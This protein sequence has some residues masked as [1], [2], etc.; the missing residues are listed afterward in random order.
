MSKP[1]DGGKKG[2]KVRV[3][4]RKNRG[5]PSRDNDWTRQFKS[6]TDQVHE[7]EQSENVR[8][9]GDSSR[10]RTII[11]GDESADLALQRGIVVAMR[12]LVAEVDDGSRLWACSVRRKLRTFLITQ[13]VPIAVGDQVMFSPVAA[14]DEESRFVSGDRNLPEGVVERVL[15][16]Q[17]LL[18]RQ[19]ERK[20]Q[21]VAANVDT[22]F[23]TLAADQPK[24]RPHLI[25]RYL[26]AVHAGKMRPIICINKSDL[27]ADEFAAEVAERYLQLGYRSLYIS[28]E[29]GIGLDE[30]RELLKD[31]TSVFV[32]PSGVGKSSIINALEPGF[33]L[34]IGTLSDLE[35]GRHT[36][37]TARLLR[38]SFG[39][40]VV[41]TPGMRQFELADVGS[42]ELEAY[43][44]EFVDLIPN[45]KFQNC[46]HRHEK[47]C[48]VIAAVENEQIT[49][50]RFE[51]YVKMFEECLEREKF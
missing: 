7:A 44:K 51:S 17:T 49:P 25:D 32:G 26:V 41:D 4:M 11:V 13:R 15:P 24:L 47:G 22:A 46:T 31:Q 10:K 29:R 45:C 2:R 43:F 23:I 34:K 36:T 20:V 38:W 27:D 21:V 33:D 42:Q 50:E 40:Y 1:G 3:E 8:S 5:K 9:K 14:G 30:L 28:V 18:L 19:Y 39:G 12:G 6:G 16:R 37:T 35:R 48:A